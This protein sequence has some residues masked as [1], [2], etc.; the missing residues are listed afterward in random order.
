MTTFLL[1]LFADTVGVPNMRRPN[2]H[3]YAFSMH[4]YEI[5]MHKDV[6][7]LPIIKRILCMLLPYVC[8]AVQVKDKPMTIC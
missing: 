5:S 6:Q 4:L 2:V 1:V 8:L 7:W 3:L